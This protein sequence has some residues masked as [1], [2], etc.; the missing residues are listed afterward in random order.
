MVAE[1]RAAAGRCGVAYETVAT[2]ASPA[3]HAVNVAAALRGD[4]A[5]ERRVWG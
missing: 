3:H 1:G 5:M 4:G 2:V